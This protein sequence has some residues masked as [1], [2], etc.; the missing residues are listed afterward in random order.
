MKTLALVVIALALVALA[1]FGALADVA[2]GH[3]PALLSPA[4]A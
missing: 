1:L 2:R 4:A 3:R